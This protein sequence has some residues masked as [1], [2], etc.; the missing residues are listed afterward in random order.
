MLGSAAEN[1]SVGSVTL[2][3]GHVQPVWAG[4]PW[5]FAQAIERVEGG[6]TAGDEVIVKDARG[7]ALG[8]GL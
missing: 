3:A 8:R 2:R 1:V 4:H 6:M 7:N 5:V